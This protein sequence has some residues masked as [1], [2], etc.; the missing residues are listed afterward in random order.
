MARVALVTGG[1]RGIGEAI[2]KALKAAG[3]KVAASYAGNDAAAAKFKEATG[4]PVFKWDVGSFEACGEGIKK[5]EA[6]LGPIE[7]LV[8][9]AGITKDTPFHRMSLEQWNAVINTNLG[10]MFNMTRQVYRR[11]ACAKI[12]PHHQHLLDQRPEGPVRPGELFRGE[13]RRHRLH[14]GAGAGGRARRHHRQCDLPGL[15]QHR[16]GA[17]G[18]EGRAGEERDLADPE[19]TGSAS[20]RR[21]RARWCSL[22]PT[23]RASSTARP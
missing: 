16:D 21:S 2:S 23:T 1:T 7:V 9:N 17:G 22:P 19:R 8:N 13:G 11:H 5:V 15:H 12:R 14:Q 18:A 6:E 10:S 3:Y 20:R 4:I